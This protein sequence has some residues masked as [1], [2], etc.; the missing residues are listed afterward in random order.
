MMMEIMGLHLPGA[1]FVNP[2][3][4]LRD[5]L[6]REAAK[7]AMA[8]TALG[9]DYRPLGQMLDERSFANAL[10]ALSATGGSTNHTLHLIVMAAAAGITLTWDDFSDI[11]E[12]TPLL[13]HIYPNGKA[14][15]NYFHAAGGTGFIIRELLEAGLLH[16]DAR[17]VFGD[18]LADYAR[19]PILAE[20]GSIGWRDAATSSG[21][22]S[23]LRGAAEPFQPTG[24][25]KLLQGD[26]GRAMMKTSAVAPERRV[27]EA[28][29]RVFH[30]QEALHD[31]FKAGELHRDCI[32]VVRFQGP[33]ANGMPELHRLMPPLGVLQDKGFQV[34]LLTDG[35]LSGASGKVPAALH[36]TPEA[37]EG[38]P[39]AKIRD[40]DIIR[41]DA[42][43]GTLDVLVEPAEWAARA[44]VV[45]DLSANQFGVGREL[46]AAFRRDV[47]SADTGATIFTGLAA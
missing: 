31:A 30:D 17:T 16:A 44:P 42:V 29:A 20:D 9:N 46:F 37:A 33:K 32:A 43:A 4:P 13:A 34:A 21:D 25:L 40:G 35:R 7:R 19:E 23:V 36:V 39:I 5:A 2:N 47:G 18:G 41:I 14:D 15:V 11:A 3:T 26:L 22:A 38:G 8:I 28:P 45:A 27:I 12:V 24:G 1:A 6:T 10:A